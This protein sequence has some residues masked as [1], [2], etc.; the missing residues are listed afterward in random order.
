MIGSDILG[1]HDIASMG[2]GRLVKENKQSEIREAIHEIINN[3]GGYSHA[4]KV[5]AN[6][7]SF[8]VA[9]NRWL[10]DMEL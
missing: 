4:A 10:D 9:S 7:N 6:E 5:F 2:L 8:Y 3:Y 1:L